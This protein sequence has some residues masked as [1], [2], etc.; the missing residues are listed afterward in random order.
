MVLKTHFPNVEHLIL[1]GNF[2]NS[3]KKWAFK[4]GEGAQPHLQR[5]MQGVYYGPGHDVVYDPLC[6]DCAKFIGGNDAENLQLKES[7]TADRCKIKLV[8]EAL[9]TWP[10]TLKSI[11]LSIE[12][13]ME[14][15]PTGH[16]WKYVHLYETLD[17]KKIL[18]AIT[19]SNNIDL[20]LEQF[21][22]QEWKVQKMAY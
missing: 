14:A 6:V 20:L 1:E 3:P 17:C 2:T 22:A 13:F 4:T 15:K 10:K 11:S 21:L 8:L 12:D 9:K 18:E 16:E 7:T 5:I 19:A